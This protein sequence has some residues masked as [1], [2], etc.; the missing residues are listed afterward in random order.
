MTSIPLLQVGDKITA[1]VALPNITRGVFEWTVIRVNRVT[2]KVFTAPTPGSYMCL[3][4]NKATGEIT[5]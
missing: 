1:R 2:Y 3:Y 5:R 4:M